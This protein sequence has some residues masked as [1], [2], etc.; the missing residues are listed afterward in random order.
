MTYKKI[1]N[2]PVKN[3]VF[4][5]PMQEINDI[6][7][8]LL[9]KKAG[10]EVTYTGMIHPRT[11]Q[12]IELIDNP[13]LQLFCTYSKGIKE[14]MK[15][16]DKDV[17]AWDFNLGCPAKNAK[18][19]C[20]GFFMNH[21]LE[22]IE[23]ILKTMRESTK[24]PLFAKLRKSKNTFKILKLA[25]KYCDAICI[26]PRTQP[27][28]YSGFAD[29]EYALNLKKQTALPVIYSGDVTEKNYKEL[30]EDF[31]YIMIGRRAIGNPEIFS[32]TSG[33]N[34]K[35]LEKNKTFSDKKNTAFKDYLELAEKYNLPF[36]QLKLQ[37]MNFTKGIDNATD[38][39]EQIIKIK[40]KK[41]LKG[42]VEKNMF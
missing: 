11:K 22:D 38:L 31:D 35:P 2:F 29:K 30:L 10:C 26:H 12:K 27:Q 34:K 17:L 5:A 37:A 40:T 32:I 24:K 3:R 8:R 1:P 4:L 9:C 16:H 15:K 13:V 21:K 19:H 39:R 7:F 20:F 41:S 33:K 23:D 25:E 18:K 28:G 14:F 42:F 36:R 6:A